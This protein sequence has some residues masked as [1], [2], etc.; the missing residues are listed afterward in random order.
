MQGAIPKPST[1]KADVLLLEHSGCGA[2]YNI[3]MMTYN[4][5]YNMVVTLEVEAVEDE[6]LES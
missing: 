2:I 1:P 3:T 6:Q 4:A 5:V